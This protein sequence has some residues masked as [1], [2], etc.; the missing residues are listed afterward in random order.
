MIKKK[1]KS[2]ILILSIT[3]LLLCGCDAT[4][5]FGEGTAKPAVSDKTQEEGQAVQNEETVSDDNE[6]SDNANGEET[7]NS[8]EDGENKTDYVISSENVHVYYEGKNILEDEELPMYFLNGNKQIP[9]YDMDTV[10]HIMEKLYNEGYGDYEKDPNYSLSYEADENTVTFTREN[11]YDM[12]LD[13]EGDMIYFTD[14]D[15]FIAHSYDMTTVDLSHSSGFDDEGNP[16]YLKRVE[17]ES[18]ERY[19]KEY[20]INLADYDID[21]I[22]TGDG[23]Y[24]PA[25]TMADLIVSSTYTRYIYNGETAFY[26]NHDN[27][28]DDMLTMQGISPMVYMTL[29]QERSQELIDFTYNELCMVLDHEYGMKDIHG[30]ESFNDY[31]EQLGYEGKSLKSMICSEDAVEMEKGIRY[32]TLRGFD[33]LHSTYYYPGAY[34][35]LES[36]DEIYTV[37]QGPSNSRYRDLQSKYQFE[38]A[39]ALSD[40]Q[41][42]IPAY[43]EVGNTAYIT[44]D[45]FTPAQIDYYKNPPK[46]V[47]DDTVGLLIYAHSMITREHSPIE[48]VVLD[49]SCN[50][51]GAEDAVAFVCAWFLKEAQI[52]LQNPQ[53]GASSVNVYQC[54]ANLDH[55]FDDRDSVRDY[56]RYCLISPTSFSCGNLAPCVFD[57]SHE[58]TLIGQNTGGGASV[59]LPLT[60]ASGSVFS[61]SGYRVVSTMKNGSFYNADLGVSPM[62]PLTE[63][64]SFYDRQALTEY[65]NELK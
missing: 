38:R 14:F 19:G 26:I 24:I 55:E 33:D 5:N 27:F 16:I 47:P 23:Y 37:N 43:Q 40:E 11:K 52:Y 15:M 21:L 64:K 6:E 45:S 51:G 53:T 35:G 30:I 32:L 54:D 20:V 7:Q 31:F 28:K 39:M 34:A 2:I 63:I 3:G 12:V 44:F 49:L 13:F 22:A 4:V 61:V 58:V 42:N 29:K 50:S 8:K 60:T 1:S 48:N 17:E 36:M 57:C 59:I 41:R 56:N 65:I 25:Q 18:S 10:C 62:L 9:Y 46:E